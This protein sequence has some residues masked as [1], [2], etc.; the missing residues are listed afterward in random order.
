MKKRI[1]VILMIIIFLLLILAIDTNFLNIDEIF[2]CYIENLKNT[3]LTMFFKLVT[4][5][6]NFLWC[7]II[8]VIISIFFKSK[9]YLII[10]ISVIFMKTFDLV[11]K[12]IIKR[13]RPNHILIN[14]DSF[15]FPASHAAL[16]MT[17]YGLLII[18]IY[19]KIQKNSVKWLLIILLSILILIIGV[20]RI[21][22]GV[23]YFTDVLGG[24][25]LG[26]IYLVLI[27]DTIKE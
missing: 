5:L 2:N 12:V 13:P 17:L 1:M 14:A 7:L 11:I 9:S 10:P 18:L 6:R 16:S 15:S 22:L 27:K 24:Y 20:S 4:K 21:Y 23:H 25:I 8:G 3:N 26:L 19:R